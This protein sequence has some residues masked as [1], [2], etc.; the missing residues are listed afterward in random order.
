V[1]DTHVLDLGDW[2]YTTVIARVRRHFEPVISDPESIELAWVPIDELTDYNL[3]SGVA[4]ALPE[5]LEML[6]PHL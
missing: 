4:A 6:R 1:L 5:L 3:H 2:S